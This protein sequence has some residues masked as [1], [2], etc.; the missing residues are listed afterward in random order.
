[1]DD[2]I[3]EINTELDTADNQIL[4]GDEQLYADSGQAG[5]TTAGTT[6]NSLYSSLGVQLGFADDDLISFSGITHSGTEVSGTYQIEDITTD[7]VQGLLSAIENAYSNQVSASIDTSGRIVLQDNS[8]GNSQLTLSSISHTDEGEFFGIV[9]ITDGAGDGSQQGHNAMGLTA[10]VDE[11]GRLVIRSDAYGSSSAFSISQSTSQ[12]GL[13]DGTYTGLDVAGTIGGEPATGSGQ[14]LTGNDGN[15]NTEGLS[16]RYRGT[17]SNV[18]AGTITVSLGLAEQLDRVLFNITDSIDGYVT[19][20][21]TS[22]KETISGID[23]Q[24]EQIE[25]RLDK[26]MQRLINQYVAMEMTLNRLQSQSD[27]LAGQTSALFSGWN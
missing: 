20:K 1:M 14:I 9:D 19:Y 24:V 25:A 11:N 21:Q 27:W 8:E 12:L 17:V 2:I 4:V 22:L 5:V 6:W 26:K 15:T 10:S 23:E 7:T 16:I 3:N 18:D 13:S